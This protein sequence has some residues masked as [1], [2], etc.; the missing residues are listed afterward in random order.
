MEK[1]SY[2]LKLGKGKF[3]MI[4]TEFLKWLISAEGITIDPAKALGLA[5]WPQK[6]C[7]LKELR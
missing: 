5:N 1:P 7:N 2:F 3:K 6:L 4:K